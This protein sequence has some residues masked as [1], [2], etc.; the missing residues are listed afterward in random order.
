MLLAL[1][2]IVEGVRFRTEYGDMDALKQ[3]INRYGLL[4][5][6]VLDRE[7]RLLAGGRRYRAC[8]M[9]GLETVPVVYIDEVDPLRAREIELEENI[10]REQLSFVEEAR[11]VQE[12]HNLKQT[13]YGT[14]IPGAMHSEGWGQTETA[15]S[16]DKSQSYVSRQLAMAAAL[17]SVPELEQAGSRKAAIKLL[18]RRL[19]EL[20]RERAVRKLKTEESNIWCGRAEE[21]L[22]R[23]ESGTVDCVIMDPPYGTAI[24]TDEARLNVYFDDSINTALSTLNAILPELKR[25]LKPD[26]HLYC[27]YGIAWHT[28]FLRAFKLAG[29]DYDP[30]PLVWCKNTIGLVDWSRRYGPAY[31]TIL[32][33]FGNRDRI[34]SERSTNVF[35]WP[36]V[37]MTDRHSGFEKP[38]E[39]AKALISLSTQE[40]ELVLDPCCG[41]GF[42][43]LA[44][45]Q[46]NR[47]Y[48]GIELNPGEV[49]ATKLRLA[50]YE[51]EQLTP[52]EDEDEDTTTD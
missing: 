33:C 47:R 39:A 12:I 21:L 30:I 27:F 34:L 25:V 24:D 14:A 38:V 50:Q 1:D 43:P 7:N 41:S 8:Q 36:T 15:T 29:F 5:P 16:L 44:A 46:L 28:E 3:S 26:G 22:K 9:L 40:G 11:L 20:E 18:E 48:I 52:T 4:Q 35:N 32:F 23:V 42:V 51:A 19:Q 10:Q 31:E 49:A 17:E 45:K 13:I 6:L 37:P 2:S